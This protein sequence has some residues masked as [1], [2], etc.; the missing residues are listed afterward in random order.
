[1]WELSFDPA[2]Q[3]T[4]GANTAIGMLR[5]SPPDTSSEWFKWNLAAKRAVT[6]MAAKCWAGIDLQRRVVFIDED[7]FQ[8][9]WGQMNLYDLRSETPGRHL[10]FEGLSA[11]DVRAALSAVY[12]AARATP[13][14]EEVLRADHQLESSHDKLIL[15]AGLAQKGHQDLEAAL[16]S[17]TISDGRQRGLEIVRTNY[18]GTPVEDIAAAFQRYNRLVQHIIWSILGLAEIAPGPFVLTDPVGTLRCTRDI[19]GI[20]F[21]R[22][23]SMEATNVTLR[24]TYPVWLDTGTPLDGLHLVVGYTMTLASG[25]ACDLSLTPIR[26]DAGCW[27]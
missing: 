16:R 3:R 9:I 6:R 27:P 15:W 17:L 5:H 12:Q 10:N 14:Y 18:A 11:P 8:P 2:I 22:V 23:S 21:I 1:M 24:I 13:A 19:D 26:S 25:A 4:L 20:P 7:N